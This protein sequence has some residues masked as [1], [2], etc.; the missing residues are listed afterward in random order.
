MDINF[1][2][3]SLK[4]KLSFYIIL[5]IAFFGTSASFLV[6]KYTQDI[7]IEKEKQNIQ[8]LAI[9][10]A[11]KIE[12][13]FGDASRL[14]EITSDQSFVKDYLSGDDS[15][16]KLQKDFVLN[17]FITYDPQKA[18][19]A[20]YLMDA[21]GDTLVSTDESSVGKNYSF[22]DY[23]K[24]AMLIGNY[25]DVSIGVTSKKLGYYFS[26]TVEDSEGETLGVIVF[27][28]KPEIAHRLLFNIEENL[29]QKE[30][31]II[32][33]YG[34]IVYSNKPENTYK[35]IVN[36][37]SSDLESIEKRKRFNGIDIE[38][39]DL[40]IFKDDLLHIDI[41]STYNIKKGEKN[42]FSTLA[43]ID[44]LPFFVY[45]EG[46]QK[47]L[48]QTIS[49]IPYILA[50]LVGGFAISAII[51]IYIAVSISLKPLVHI[52]KIVELFVS[53]NLDSRVKVTT[54]DEVG[55]LGKGFNDLV[56]KLQGEIQDVEVKVDKR[57]EQLEVI[58]KSMVGREL[59]MVELKKEILNL[60]NKLKKYE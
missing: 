58:N 42:L 53:G 30:I 8:F 49:N 41:L 44:K 57:T 56:D 19:S 34:V 43:R 2:Q 18:F 10:R 6:F 54:K 36:L 7:L 11:G 33:D 4:Y 17:K 51:L 37:N 23:F 60:K 22:R 39:F 16:R 12:Q 3:K 20:I 13:V 45:T 40:G 21:E 1:I 28:L 48:A 59:K 55:K 29:D 46:S 52:N 24:E 31:A 9:E 15:D 27:K 32:D 35:S 5:I 25:M 47:N 26:H 14:A 50:M 38:S